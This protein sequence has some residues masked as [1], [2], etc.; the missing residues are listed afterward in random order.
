MA[1]TSVK[2][3]A[4]QM[5]KVKLSEFEM[6]GMKYRYEDVQKMKEHY[7]AEL[8]KL[9]N[10]SDD[11]LK[12]QKDQI[13]MLVAENQALREVVD[14]A[15]ER[16]ILACKRAHICVCSKCLDG[17]FCEV[18]K[19][20]AHIACDVPHV[21]GCEYCRD[22]KFCK[23]LRDWARNACDLPHLCLC[24]MCGAGDYCPGAPDNSDIELDGDVFTTPKE[25]TGVLQMEEAAVQV[26]G[27]ALPVIAKTAKKMF[28]EMLHD[29]PPVKTDK[30]GDYSLVDL[31]RE[32]A[33]YG[34][35]TGDTH[36]DQSEL[37]SLTKELN[38]RTTS[39][40]ARCK[41]ESRLTIIN[42]KEA[43]AV[44]ATLYTTPVHPAICEKVTAGTPPY[45]TFQHT[46]LSYF[47]QFY[48]FW[49]GGLRFTIECLPTRFHQGQLYIAFNPNMATMTLVR[50]RNCTAATI[51]LGLN[52]RTTLDVPFVALTDYLDV[53][54][55]PSDLTTATLLNSL[56]RKSVV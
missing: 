37:L 17:E 30:A 29:T 46:A 42:W 24:G 53:T 8:T 48:Y 35:L 4:S 49:R 27:A 47:S 6:K 34:F 16:G 9:K 56:D 1:T 11:A 52:N 51:D 44:A 3:L 55:L 32:V 40:L 43:D 28:G 36:P 12:Y 22:E 50:A 10:Q 13:D 39:L 15:K 25:A 41:I 14:E 33:S 54:T 38:F 20:W 31:P 45:N 18:T 5:H 7:I 26:L 2:T 19:N 21:C 23:K